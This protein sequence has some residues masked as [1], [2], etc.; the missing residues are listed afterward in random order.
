MPASCLMSFDIGGSS[1]RCLVVD[2][3]TGKSHC[4]SY[5]GS[6]SDRVDENAWALSLNTDLIWRTLGE[7]TR[8]AMLEAD[9]APDEIISIAA[10]SFRH[11]LV[12]IDQEGEVLFATPNIDARASC[13][14][15]DLASEYGSIF[16]QRTG[17]WPCPIM[18]APRLMWLSK[19]MPE[20][21]RQGSAVLS[22][23]DWI[24]FK[25]TGE[26]RSERSQAAE[27]LLFDLNSRAW[28]EDLIKLCGLPLEWF[29]PSIDAGESLGSLSEEA[30]SHL[31]LA[32]GIPVGM[33]G[34]DTQ[35]ALLGLGVAQPGQLAVISGSTTPIQ[36]VCD[37]P[38]SDSN[39]KL[40]TGLHAIPNL[41]VL[42]SNAGRT[43][44]SLEWVSQILYPE[45]ENASAKFLAEA[46]QSQPGT[47]RTYSTVGAN[48]FNAQEM[49]LPLDSLSF[50]SLQQF[51]AGTARGAI[52][53]AVLE[54]M[55][56]AVRANIEQIQEIVGE[57]FEE[58]GLGGG[59]SQSPSWRQTLGVVTDSNIYYSRSPHTSAL[60]AAICAG[61]S[62]GI[63]SDLSSGANTLKD[64]ASSPSPDQEITRMY[65]SLYSDWRQLINLRLD[66]DI[67]AGEF[68]TEALTTA[69][70]AFESNR[71]LQ[72][73]PKIFVSAEFDPGSLDR[74][75]E[76]GEV[77]YESYRENEQFLVGDDLVE[78]LEGFHVFITEVDILDAQ[79]IKEL[80]ELRAVFSCRGNPVNIDLAA[81][82]A[83]GIPLMNAPGRNAEA[84]ADLTLAYMLMLA[85]NLNEASE[86]LRQPGG[87]AGDM[88]RMGMAHYQLQGHELWGKTL[89]IIG[90]GAVGR[91]VIRRALPFGMC[92]LVYDPA[93]PEEVI[94]LLGAQ[95]CD[96]VELLRKSNFISLHA[97]LN[98]ETKGMF[99]AQAFAKMRK[100][101]FL[102]NTARAGLVDED[103]LLAAL[104]TQAIGGAALDVFAVE[105]PAS[106]DPILAFPNVI[107]TPHVGGNTHEVAEHQGALVLKDLEALLRGNLPANILNPD[108]LERFSWE[109]ERTREEARLDALIQSP[110]PSVSD[111]ELESQK[112]K[113]I[114]ESPDDIEQAQQDVKSTRPN[115]FGL[116]PGV[117]KGIVG[118][119]TDTVV[120]P[121]G[122]QEIARIRER[123]RA[124]LERFTEYV[125]SE[126]ALVDFST[127]RDVIFSILVKDLDLRFFMAFTDGV[128]DSSLRDPPRDVDVNLK[129]SAET[130]DGMFLGSINP[131]RAAMS[132]K[133]S[134]SGNTKKAMAFQRALKDIQRLYQRAREEVGDPGDLARLVAKPS[135]PAPSSGAEATIQSSQTMAAALNEFQTIGDIR[136]ELL[137]IN[138]ELFAKG[139]ITPTGG[140]VSVRVEDTLQ[141]AWITPSQ[142]YK[143][144]LRPEM[145]V[146]IDLDGNLIGEED[147]EA[148]SERRVHC[149]IYRA[150][151]DI[152]VVAHTHA[153]F[154]TLLAL[155]GTQFLPIST[156]AAFV[157]DIPVVPFIMP[158]TDELGDAVAEALGD[159]CAVIM[160]NHGLVVAASSLRRAADVS[161]VI[162]VTA[163]K[164][165]TCKTL[166][167]EPP[168]LPADI[169]E[170]LRQIGKM[171]V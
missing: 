22:V 124:I 145:M 120:E 33:G 168:V 74:L 92:V 11:G 117:F 103:A 71:P 30:A 104:K 102:I 141:E 26:C 89:G 52:A 150:R 55:A 41:Y 86:F 23:S 122:D 166:G 9:I 58:F 151:S 157:G 112:S 130:L 4:V 163:E 114:S 45:G 126:P 48:I 110:G 132:G 78:R 123:M 138:N 134:F 70:S 108:V 37:S 29:P 153:K 133:L 34:A 136:D 80:P 101:A 7:L 140:N 93:I 43:G 105:P 143:G 119:E 144:D 28:A 42:E 8:Q 13:E 98:R 79:T 149:A 67:K 155:T 147:I 90:A 116:V 61:V 156:E 10:T 106:D 14:S 91:E 72:F 97:P 100:G 21:F 171:M 39:N 95:N 46:A 154:A 82:T 63:Y 38:I 94:T 2:I 19:E 25:C 88:G 128:V 17:H 56:F 36:Y 115:R 15:S 24:G 159:G 75:N 59:L 158:G 18:M 107:A 68:I 12:L 51:Q 20:I 109:G 77:T 165:M 169:V 6:I 44:A 64:I 3:N 160:Q 54:G 84:V 129:M 27:S 131:T 170:E 66:A 76:L 47:A 137:Q 148:S 152:Q 65:S 139:Y 69:H 164:I 121:I 146:R 142:I 87:E 125:A 99:N 5:Y 32:H 50:S 62:S 73:K 49:H 161:D 118:R 167:I 16:S 40:W 127:G 31:D 81:C 135:H 35:C 1:I 60:G 83:V 57:K 53:R 113:I 111:L 85:R 96:F 162:E